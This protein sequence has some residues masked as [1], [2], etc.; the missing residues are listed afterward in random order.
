MARN[1]LS[2]QLRA[3]VASGV[4]NQKLNQRL[5][6]L[7]TG[8]APAL[9]ATDN[10]TE[11]EAPASESEADTPDEENALERVA[12]GEAPEPIS[13]VSDVKE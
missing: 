4:L 3:T 5:I 9:T 6:A 11:A 8:A 13:Q 2:T 10:D 7:A 12:T 1:L